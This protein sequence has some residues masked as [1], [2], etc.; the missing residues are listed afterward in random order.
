MVDADK[1]KTQLDAFYRR[2]EMHS[3]DGLVDLLNFLKNSTLGTTFS[4]I[5]KVLEILITIPMCS[6]EAERTFSTLKRIKTY[7]R[8]TMGQNRLNA[9][10]ILSI[11]HEL[12][13]DIPTFNE[14]V[15]NKFITIKNRRMDF[16][17]KG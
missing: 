8:N 16:Q 2:K 7:L 5:C 10:G 17:Y 3:F 14:E 4:E 6:T 12:I 15:L 11:G 13:S 9:L 1:L